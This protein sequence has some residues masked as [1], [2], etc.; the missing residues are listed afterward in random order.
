MCG[1]VVTVSPPHF[2]ICPAANVGR[3]EKKHGARVNP[4][5]NFKSSIRSRQVLAFFHQEFG[6]RKP[7]PIIERLRDNFQYAGSRVWTMVSC[8]LSP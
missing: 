1:F 5:I 8:M 4:E 3:R 2:H 7:L 6:G